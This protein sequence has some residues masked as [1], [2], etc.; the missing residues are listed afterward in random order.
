VHARGW[1]N[2]RALLAGNVLK[3]AAGNSFEWRFAVENSKETLTLELGVQIRIGF[4][5]IS[6]QKYTYRIGLI[7]LF[8]SRIGL[9]YSK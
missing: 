8:R 2:R 3:S 1:K 5:R 7:K 9:R 4:V 6:E